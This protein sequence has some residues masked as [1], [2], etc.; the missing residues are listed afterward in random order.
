ML[1]YEVWLYQEMRFAIFSYGENSEYVTYNTDGQK[2]RQYCHEMF[3]DLPKQRNE[4]H[5]YDEH[6]LFWKKAM[7]TGVI[8][9]M[10]LAEFT[11]FLLPY[12]SKILHYL[13]SKQYEPEHLDAVS[14]C[15]KF[16]RIMRLT[17]LGPVVFVAFKVW[18]A[19]YE[20]VIVL[21]T[22]CKKETKI[23]YTRYIIDDMNYGLFDIT[24]N[25]MRN[26]EK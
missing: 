12:S 16:L 4:L 15:S 26:I 18:Q 20:F 2:I 3:F 14:G 13:R 25:E 11:P 17:I 5:C 21:L 19:I 10:V 24:L 9:L 6:E 7:Y 23:K 8:S 22:L 1:I